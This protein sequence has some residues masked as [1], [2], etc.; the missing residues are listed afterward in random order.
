MNKIIKFMLHNYIWNILIIKSS[1]MYNI[2]I[3]LSKLTTGVVMTSLSLVDSDS[4]ILNTVTNY[5][6]NFQL[7]PKKVGSSTLLTTRQNA[8][9]NYDSQCNRQLRIKVVFYHSTHG[10]I[11]GRSIKFCHICFQ[12][13]D[14]RGRILL[15]YHAY[16]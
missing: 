13:P 4:G 9:D 2:N 11:R 12:D 7:Q 15:L 16:C 14:S 3:I 1:G 8:N 5:N 10:K 6:F